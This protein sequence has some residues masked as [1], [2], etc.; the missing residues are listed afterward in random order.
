MACPAPLTHRAELQFRL[1]L[2]LAVLAFTLVA[3]S[4]ARTTPRQGIYGRLGAAVVIYFVFM[5]LQRVSERWFE[6]GLSPR[7]GIALLRASRA[8]KTTPPRR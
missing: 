8:Q 2:P 7:A 1:S 5:N 3:V 6:T 4:L